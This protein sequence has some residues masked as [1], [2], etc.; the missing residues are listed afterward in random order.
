MATIK[1]R[2]EWDF[3]EEELAAIRDLISALEPLE[4]AIKKLGTKGK[5]TNKK[6]FFSRSYI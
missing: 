5:S 1:A 4:S 3:T 2:N 6:C